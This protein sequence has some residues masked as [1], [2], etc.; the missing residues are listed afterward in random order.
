MHALMHPSA[1]STSPHTPCVC[2]IGASLRSRAWASSLSPAHTPALSSNMHTRRYQY[3]G[4]PSMEVAAIVSPRAVSRVEMHRFI[5]VTRTSPHFVTYVISIVDTLG[6]LVI[7][8]HACHATSPD[9]PGVEAVAHDAVHDDSDPSPA[10]PR[11]RA[12]SIRSPIPTTFRSC[13]VLFEK[14]WYR[15]NPPTMPTPQGG[16]RCRSA[17]PPPDRSGMTAW[18]VSIPAA[19]AYGAADLARNAQREVSVDRLRHL[20]ACAGRR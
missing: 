4:C 7:I 11:W 14:P 15:I 5:P 19:P 20:T 2:G 12:P 10:A 3:S 18:L 17:M 9:D 13:L 6:G 1:H 8:A 16:S